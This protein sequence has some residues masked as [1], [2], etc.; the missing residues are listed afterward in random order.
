[1][2]RNHLPQV[3]SVTTADLQRRILRIYD[4]LYANASTR[5][6]AGIAFE[7]GK[8]LHTAL[9][10]EE[11][12]PGL[13]ADKQFQPPAFR[14]DSATLKLIGKGDAI[15]CN[16]V[17]NVVQ[18]QFCRMNAAWQFYKEAEQ[19]RLK[20]TD[21]AYVCGELD[22]VL[23]SEKERDVFGDALEIFRGQWAKRAG[24]QFFTDQ[25]VTSLAMTLLN[26]DPCQGDDLVDLSAG[27]GGF[28]L[29]GLNHIRA[30][31]EETTDAVETRLVHLAAESLKGQ[32][33]DAEVCEIANATLTSRLG[34]V[35]HK[36]VAQGDSLQPDIFTQDNAARIRY[37]THRCAATNPP[38]GTKITLKDESL[39]KTYELALLGGR[40][41]A[42]SS[43]K[44]SRRAPDILFLEQN[45]KILQPGQG[46]LAIVVPYQI[47]SGPQTCYVRQWLLRQ[48]EI[49]AVIDLP[50]D[51][52]Q[53]HTG[54][55][56]ALLVVKRRLRPL[57]SVDQA[58]DNPIF[59][60]MPRWIGHDRRGNP[61]YRRESDGGVAGEILSDFE[62]V[63][64]AFS[65]FQQGGD[66]AAAH[67]E[68]FSL[69][70]K[71]SLKDPLLRLNAAFYKPSQALAHHT[72]QN[73]PEAASSWTYHRLRDVVKRIYY[74]GRF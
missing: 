63:K 64:N 68:S 33:I 35:D 55:K 50:A 72:A 31:L 44:I 54:T 51:T 20:E 47:L 62:A 5:T 58:P 45:I 56:G 34:L 40:N 30:I 46:R 19:I 8:I 28:L 71:E 1:M 16:M 38:F 48:A 11:Q 23:V 37:G 69:S 27:S 73:L 17:A 49:L 25:R 36:L 65:V 21:L 9:F 61:V 57:E 26:F 41:G 70:L 59:M 10:M 66:I 52:F 43:A 74:P 53:P 60:S 12:Q 7:V 39:L 13:L 42:A 15:T 14:F 24:G 4:H 2:T 32:E 22:G 3:P 18:T 6:G 29:A 67:P